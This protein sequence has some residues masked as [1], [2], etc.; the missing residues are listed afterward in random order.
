MKTNSNN[1]KKKKFF[2]TLFTNIIAVICAIDASARIKS[3]LCGLIYSF[4]FIHCILSG[5]LISFR[6]YFLTFALAGF[7]PLTFMHFYAKY[8]WFALCVALKKKSRPQKSSPR[9]F[10]PPRQPSLYASHCLLMFI[11]NVNGIISFVERF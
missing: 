2:S 10:T 5:C 7:C 1:K 6:V 4:A 9:K 11:I 8:L 3:I